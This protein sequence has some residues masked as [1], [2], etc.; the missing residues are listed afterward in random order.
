MNVKLA[1]NEIIKIYE[2]LL[3]P[4][5]LLLSRFGGR[6][7]EGGRQRG[8]SDPY[9]YRRTPDFSESHEGGKPLAFGQEEPAVQEG[10]GH[11]RKSPRRMSQ[12]QHCLEIKRVFPSSGSPTPCDPC[13]SWEVKVESGKEQQTYSN[14]SVTNL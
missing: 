4:L 13:L 11:D 1:S 3:S 5:L 12:L 2:H 14:I 8:E 10:R 9:A 6:Q 7:R